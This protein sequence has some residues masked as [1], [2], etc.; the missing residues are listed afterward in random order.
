MQIGYT[1]P[2]TTIFGLFKCVLETQLQPQTP[3]KPN[4]NPEA[5]SNPNPKKKKGKTSIYLE[6]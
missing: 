2:L 4:P 5:N 1:K 6:S 3:P